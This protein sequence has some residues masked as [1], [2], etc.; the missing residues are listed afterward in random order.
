MKRP[1]LVCLAILPLLM[2]CTNGESPPA[3][4]KPAPTP[5]AAGATGAIAPALE[6]SSWQVTHVGD[7]A[8]ARTTIAFKEGR[9][10][11]SG[12]CNRY[13]G[14]VKATAGGSFSAGSFESGQVAM[15][16]MACPDEMMA[17]EQAFMN[18]LAEAKRWAITSSGEL[19]LL[20]GDRLLVRATR[21]PAG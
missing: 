13:M 18:A 16:M 14:G 12:G 15:T 5:P 3:P 19:Q 2:A 17:G 10:Y 11:G 7:L 4:A 20:A 9:I 6:G 1:H 21:A 8:V